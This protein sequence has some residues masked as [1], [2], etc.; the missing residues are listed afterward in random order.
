[1][2]KKKRNNR[3]VNREVNVGLISLG[4]P[5]NTV[6]SETM[7]GKL[8]HEGFC[9]VGDIE[10]ADAVI[11]NTCGFI[12]PARQ[13][14]IEQLKEAAWY[15]ENGRLKCVIAAGC[16]AQRM[17]KELL[18]QVPQIDAIVGLSDRD[19]IAR[20]VA[21]SVK[22]FEKRC[23][24]SQDN[25]F[26]ADD[27]GRLLTTPPHYA[28]LRI[29]EGCDRHC[30][31]CTI[32]GIR[33]RFR[34]KELKAVARE[35]LELS[36]SGVKE[37]IIIA[38]DSSY[39]GK[40]LGMQ[41]GLVELLGVL[42]NFDFKWIRVMY[43]YPANLSD[44][45]IEKIAVSKKILP[46]IDIPIQHINN[47]ILKSMKRSDT[48]EKTTSLIEKLRD[49][50]PDIVLR[51]T[52]ITGFP[53]ETPRQHSQLIEFI[54]WAK[55]DAL[56]CFTFFAEQGTAAADMPDQVPEQIKTRRQQEI[57]LTQ[58]QVAFAKNQAMIGRELEVV[59]DRV[60]EDGTAE[61]RYYGQAPE[62]DAMCL[63]TNCKAKTGKFITARVTDY[64]DYDLIVSHIK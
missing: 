26:V 37:L 32:P 51:T 58:Q 33:G 43:L 12:E 30:A 5:K 60:Y 38:Q 7:L 46:Y 14:A 64:Q 63:V 44:K 28:Y 2:A 62:I 48:E 16:L 47:E 54:K 29:S 3:N 17:G 35:A 21:D 13:E 11:V 1:M 15:K 23:Y 19:K 22:S 20:I 10:M 50:I 8:A 18:E 34:S 27:R 40:D 36:Q 6:D 9:I 25:D 45:L 31:F 52:V 59:I 55:F 57:M 56:G 42:E 39:Y 41:E 61:G 53:G 4:C 49:R 24:L